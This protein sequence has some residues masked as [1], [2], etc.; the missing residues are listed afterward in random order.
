[1]KLSI[2]TINYNNRDGLQKTIDSVISQIY[3]D[4]EWIII[5]GG[6]TDGSKELIERYADYMTYWVSEPDKGIYNAMNKGILVS[7]G[8]YLLFL[9]S[10]DC[11]YDMGVIK[12]VIPLL[13]GKDIYVGYEQLSSC[14][15]KQIKDIYDF[16][17]EGVVHRLV[18][19]GIPH[20]ATF[21]HRNV[22]SVYGM[23]REDKQILSD[24]WVL[25]RSLV[26]GCATIVALPIIISIYDTTGI[27]ITRKDL[28][29]REQEDL[30]KENPRFY[31]L[32]Q[33]YRDNWEIV[34]AI[35]G[36]QFFFWLFRVYFYIY[37]RWLR[38]KE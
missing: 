29:L 23:Y 22:F 5:D 30:L 21:F 34:N 11:L 33:F 35:K 18:F 28:L 27:S 1:M 19:K 36:N 12:K 32:Y 20:Q 24:L 9:N 17:P 38:K 15:N 3:K 7:Q 37:R 25:Y 8:E 4:F 16:T 13:C 10:G 2:I 6:S 14:P 26:F 31:Y